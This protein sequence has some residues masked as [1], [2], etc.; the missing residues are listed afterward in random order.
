[1]DM[2]RSQHPKQ[3]SLSTPLLKP[4]NSLP[5][6]PAFLP[7]DRSKA[8]KYRSP[9]PHYPKMFSRLLAGNVPKMISERWGTS[10]E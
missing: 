7:L 5:A 3:S 4:S 1:M 8:S 6:S 2:P 9:F 10:L